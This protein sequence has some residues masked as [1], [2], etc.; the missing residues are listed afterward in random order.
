MR[1]MAGLLCLTVLCACDSTRTPTSPAPS[2]TTSPP[3]A[4]T[5]PLAPTTLRYRVSG[6]VTDETGTRLAG[7]S[8]GVHYIPDRPNGAPST[9]SSTCGW[10]GCLL[11]AL[12]NSDGFFELEFNAQSDP[13]F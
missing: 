8:V 10:D 2:W 12:T 1:K 3:P 11:S 7:V 13:R 4:P 6:R 5:A 9:P